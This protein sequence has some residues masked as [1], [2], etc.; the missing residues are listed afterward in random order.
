MSTKSHLQDQDLRKTRLPHLYDLYALYKIL[1]SFNECHQ[2]RN[3]STKSGA[4][5]YSRASN[6]LQ[7][8]RW[9]IIH[10]DE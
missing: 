10:L 3:F 6:V 1:I 8:R 5:D 7:R 9:Q 4:I 2:T